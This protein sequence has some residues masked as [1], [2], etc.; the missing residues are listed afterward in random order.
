MISRHLYTENGFSKEQYSS[1]MI[2]TDLHRRRQSIC[3][4]VRIEPENPISPSMP[5]AKFKPT[6][7]IRHD[8]LKSRSGAKPEVPDSEY[9]TWVPSGSDFFV[10]VIRS[11]AVPLLGSPYGSKS[12]KPQEFHFW[13]IKLR[14]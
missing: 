2:A 14:G 5:V 1:T 10:P 6:A 13:T 4:P 12:P 11:I 3:T 9:S 7:H 8:G